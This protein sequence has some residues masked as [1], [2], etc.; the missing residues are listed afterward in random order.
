[1][2]CDFNHLILC[3]MLIL[4]H[5][6]IMHRNIQV[7]PEGPTIVLRRI[8]NRIKFIYLQSVKKELR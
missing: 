6:D 1:M 2:R 3:A 8:H 5:D 7:I 4:S